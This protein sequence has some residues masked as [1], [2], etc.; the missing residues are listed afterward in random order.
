MELALHS[1]RTSSLYKNELEK[2]TSSVV[3]KKTDPSPPRAFSLCSGVLFDST[4]SVFF[5]LLFCSLASVQCVIVK[6]LQCKMPVTVLLVSLYGR[7][8]HKKALML[9]NHTCVTERL[10]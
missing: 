6:Y 5:C 1:N 4:Y 2:K 3:E 7:L 8:V 10:S 9:S